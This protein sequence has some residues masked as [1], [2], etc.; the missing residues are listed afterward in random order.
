MDEVFK[1]LKVFTFVFG[2]Q[3]FFL[4]L[5]ILPQLLICGSHIFA[6][7]DPDLGIPKCSGS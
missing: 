3:K 2:E 1:D 5:D 4:N 6:D 7:S